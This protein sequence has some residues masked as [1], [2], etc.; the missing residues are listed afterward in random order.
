MSVSVLENPFRAGLR[1]SRAPDPCVFVLFGARGDLARRKIVPALSSLAH[2][3]LLPNSFALL[4]VGR[5]D[6]S[7]DAFR[8]ELEGSVMQA[9]RGDA[10]I[11]Q[12]LLQKIHYQKV[13]NEESESSPEL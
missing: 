4:G 5:Q 13:V 9:S 10:A 11:G 12:A 7:D 6:L 3:G 2:A 8:K 1:L